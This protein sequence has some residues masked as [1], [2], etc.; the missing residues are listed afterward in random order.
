VHFFNLVGGSGGLFSLHPYPELTSSLI[1]IYRKH[2]IHGC[3]VLGGGREGSGRPAQGMVCGFGT[4][5]LQ[6]SIKSQL[7]GIPG[8]KLR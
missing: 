4:G 5:I 8:F 2:R 6:Q 1:G 3:M 7:S